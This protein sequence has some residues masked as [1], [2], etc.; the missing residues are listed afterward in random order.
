MPVFES[1]YTYRG[2]RIVPSW[3]GSMFEAL[4]VPLFVP[5]ARWAPRSWG[6]NHPLYVR[7]QIEYGL[8]EAALRLLGL[9]PG[10]QAR[11]GLRQLWSRRPRRRSPRLLL[12]RRRDPARVVPGPGVRPARGVGQPP[13][14]AEKF[15]IYGSYGFYDSVNVST[16]Q[17]SACIL[18]LDNGMIMA[19]LANVLADDAMQHAF[20]DGPF[21]GVLRPLLAPE[22]FTAG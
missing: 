18:A 7:A 9:L 13:R 4:M 12:R 15:P 8:E 6:V 1:H 11:G 19:A 14:L 21:E 3:G 16:G 10:Q 2:M 20:V 5:E 17:V 22:E